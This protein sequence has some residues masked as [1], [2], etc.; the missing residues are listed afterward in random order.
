[1][2]VTASLDAHA[3]LAKEGIS[4]RVL[5]MPT[6]KP[7]DTAA[8]IKA[9]AETGAIV[10]AEEHQEAGGLGSVV[11]RVIAKNQPVP[12]EFVAVKDVFG[13]SGKPAE[14]LVRY[15]LT[16]KDIVKAVREVLKRKR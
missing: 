10:T 9:A 8:I 5:N 2:M 12:M 14:L 6:F 1:V 15:G 13:Q 7:I 4:C 3:E 16:S 11:A